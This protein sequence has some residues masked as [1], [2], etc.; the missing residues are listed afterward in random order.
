MLTTTFIILLALFLST[1]ALLTPQYCSRIQGYVEN[2]E[3]TNF[4]EPSNQECHN[5]LDLAIKCL[6]P[7]QSLSQAD[8]S[9][10]IPD[11]ISIDQI[12]T[13][14]E[15][16][17][18][19][20][21]NQN[22]SNT[23]LPSTNVFFVSQIIWNVISGKVLTFTIALP[24][25]T[26]MINAINDDLSEEFQYLKPAISKYI[27]SATVITT[28]PVAVYAIRTTPVITVL[29]SVLHCVIIYYQG[30]L[31]FRS[32]KSALQQ[33][34]YTTPEGW[35]APIAVFSN[36]MVWVNRGMH[37]TLRV[38]TSTMLGFL[39]TTS[40]PVEHHCDVM[41]FWLVLMI[42]LCVCIYVRWMYSVGRRRRVL[43]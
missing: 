8:Q 27:A 3:R 2:C 11:K 6:R 41:N 1:N 35:L 25:V 9:P 20:L 10:S 37:G 4:T 32:I 24:P 36:T 15:Q 12:P 30:I 18:I 13:I 7:A 33:E 31:I 23:S 17:S 38:A 26:Y 29:Y 28:V 21:A 22:L 19:I 42:L 5:F 43:M 16:S 34:L 40:V 39:K 14:P